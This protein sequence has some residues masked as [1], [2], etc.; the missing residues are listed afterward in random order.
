MYAYTMLGIDYNEDTGEARYLILDP[1]YTG[2]DNIKT[3]IDKGWCGW[4]TN[5]LFKSDTF[6]N[7]CMPIR[8]GIS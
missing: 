8:P 5:Q 4:K 3:V 1:H 6:Y 2:S 7:L